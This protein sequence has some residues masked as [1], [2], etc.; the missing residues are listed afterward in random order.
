MIDVEKKFSIVLSFWMRYRYES[1]VP[2]PYNTTKPILG[3]NGPVT[4]DGVSL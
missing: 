1:E 4:Q 3:L 2:P